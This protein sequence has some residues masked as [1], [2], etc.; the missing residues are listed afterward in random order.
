MR[1]GGCKRFCKI[2]YSMFFFLTS[3]STFLTREKNIQ[4]FVFLKAIWKKEMIWANIFNVNIQVI[5]FVV[6]LE[7]KIHK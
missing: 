7:E 1:I 4:M 5:Y 2:A 6:F 3:N